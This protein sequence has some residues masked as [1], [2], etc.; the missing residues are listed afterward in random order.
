[1]K[2]GL[3]ITSGTVVV[4]TGGSMIPVNATGTV[5]SNSW[6]KKSAVPGALTLATGPTDDYVAGYATNANAPA[7][8]FLISPCA[9]NQAGNL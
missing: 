3:G 4:A 8:Q 1:M 9:R 2:G 6:V 7:A 5:S